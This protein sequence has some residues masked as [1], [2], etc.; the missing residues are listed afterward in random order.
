MT[1]S[2]IKALV[3]ENEVLRAELQ[4]AKDTLRWYSSFLRPEDRLNDNGDKATRTLRDL[5]VTWLA[6][7]KEGV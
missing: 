2:Q 7:D 1:E 3:R 5:S 4:L 6:N